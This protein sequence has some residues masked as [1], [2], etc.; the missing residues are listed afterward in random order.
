MLYILAVLI[1]P[2]KEYQNDMSAQLLSSAPL[3]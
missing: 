1:C 2:L 3:D